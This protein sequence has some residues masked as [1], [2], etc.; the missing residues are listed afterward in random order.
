LGG[1]KRIAAVARPR[2]CPQS[3]GCGV[4]HLEAH[5][6][7]KGRLVRVREGHWKTEFAGMLGTVEACWGQSEYAAVDVRLEDGR[8]ELF[9]LTS[10]DV[11]EGATK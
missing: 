4:N 7:L 3:G 5:E 10:L 11:V 2:F 1:A 6:A 8:S 9:W